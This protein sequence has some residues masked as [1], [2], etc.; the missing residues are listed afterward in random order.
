MKRNIVAAIAIVLAFSCPAPAGDSDSRI[1]PVVLAYRKAAPAVVNPQLY[2][3]P[4][5][6][7]CPPA[8]TD[9]KVS[10]PNTATGRLLLV[11]VPSP[12]EPQELEP[13]Q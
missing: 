9:W 4:K 7:D 13:Q 3:P 10:P 2:A 12:S 6:F 1:T 8:F 11:F 5:L